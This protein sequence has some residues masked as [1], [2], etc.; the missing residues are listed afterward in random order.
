MNS[1]TTRRPA[2]FKTALQLWIAWLPAERL[3]VFE[4]VKAQLNIS[5]NMLSVALNEVIALRDKGS[6]LQAG[7]GIGLTA[8]LFDRSTAQVLMVLRTIGDQAR[9]MSALP[10][11]EPLNQENFKTLVCYR[12]A[13]TSNLLSHILLASRFRFSH[14]L[15][16]LC[17]LVEELA[18]SFRVSA[19]AIAES[20]W[21]APPSCWESLNPIHHDMNICLLET[22][23]IL[24]SFLQLLPDDVLRAFH[25]KLLGGP[26]SQVGTRTSRFASFR[27]RRATVI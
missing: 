23:I 12:K 5:Y 18:L 1:A 25:Q 7:E 10:E 9:H 16:D 24:K 26:K 6:F 20:L 27:H 11:V 8:D 19:D 21:V 15:N 14:K 17:E 13:R 22:V 4:A 3:G 2:Q